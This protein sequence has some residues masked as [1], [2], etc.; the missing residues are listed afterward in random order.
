MKRILTGLLLG[1]VLVGCSKDEE[2]PTEVRETAPCVKAAVRAIYRLET[3]V[4][5][6][7]AKP[8]F[9]SL[10]VA[11]M[12]AKDLKK[13]LSVFTHPE[14]VHLWMPGAQSWVLVEHVSTNGV[15]LAGAMDALAEDS[16]CTVSLPEA[17]ASYVGTV[18]EVLPAFEAKLEGEV[19]PEWFVTRNVPELDWLRGAYTIDDDILKLTLEEIRSMQVIRRLVL[20]GN[21]AA[22]QATDKKGEELA[23]E[24]WARAYLR[25]PNDSLL[26]ERCENLRR[27]ATGFLAVN[28]ILQAM[29]CY[30][31]LIL[32]N[33]KDITSLYGFGKCLRNVGREDLAKEV[34]KRADEL[35]KA[36]GLV[37]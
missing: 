25:N 10:D 35:V 11:G 24:K 3:A 27:N 2:R 18:E 15:S 9:V 13:K 23:T 26:N 32:I 5:E 21:M 34:Y 20:E 29:K 28:K 8:K 17:F 19:V 7:G 36:K 14:N 37:K 1:A 30:E 31:T 6:K 33:P 22:A 12:T 4:V 16:T